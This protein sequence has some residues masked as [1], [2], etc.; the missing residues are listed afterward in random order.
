[1]STYAA[2]LG[3]SQP[4]IGN[5][6][7]LGRNV[8]RL[9]GFVNFDWNVYKDFRITEGL[10]LQFRSEFYNVFNNVNFQEV[11]RTITSPSFGQ[12]ETVANDARNIQLGLRLVW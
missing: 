9:N 2:S 11:S 3:L 6:G 10:K 1:I 8:H 7:N 5:V 4:L 12:Y